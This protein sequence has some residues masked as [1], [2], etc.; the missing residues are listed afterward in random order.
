MDDYFILFKPRDIV[1]G[2]FYWIKQTDHKLVVVAADCTG[3]G[4]PGAFMSLLG[5]SYLDDIV[6][7]EGVT[8]AGQILN[9]LRQD[10]IDALHQSDTSETKEGMDMAL[11]TFDLNQ[12]K[13][14]Y[15]GANNALYLIRGDEVIEYKA[16]RM[17]VAIYTKIDDFQTNEL[18]LKK[19]DCIYMFSDGFPDQFGGPRNKKYKYK[20]FKELLMAIHKSPMEEQKQ[21][22]DDTLEAWRGENEQVDDIVVMG[23]KY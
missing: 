22:L 16:D 1:S 17:P 9:H 4:V 15:A 20:P 23:I 11:C 12:D 7:K 6:E 19:G 18:E 21:I 2:D 10:V 3:H 14:Q 5:M 8:D 13:V